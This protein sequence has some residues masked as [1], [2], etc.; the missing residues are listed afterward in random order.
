[1][2]VSAIVIESA[3]AGAIA[4]ALSAA[5]AAAGFEPQAAKASRPATTKYFDIV[6]PCRFVS[7]S[8]VEDAFCYSSIRY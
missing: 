3:G 4:A 7:Q 1:L 6:A 8:E 5:G 2:V